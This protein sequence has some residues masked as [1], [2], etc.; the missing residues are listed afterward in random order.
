[1]LLVFMKQKQRRQKKKEREKN[2]EPK[3]SNTRKTRRNKE[4]KE[5]ERDREREI[6]QVEGQKR[7]RRN[8]GRHSKI[9]KNCPFLGGKLVSCHSEAKKG[10]KNKKK[11][12][13]KQLNKTKTYQKM[14]FSI[15]SQN[16]LVFLAGVQ[17]FPFL[18]TWPRK[19]APPKHYRNRGF[20]TPI[21]EKQLCVTKRP[22][23]DKKTKPRNSSYHCF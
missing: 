14:S 4:R 20:S 3:E 22:F 19:R 18:T 10:K 7:L 17:K 13:Q 8:K 12:K 9:N 21:F 5:Q 16:C 2:K 15:I 23:L 11:K 6:E 1:M